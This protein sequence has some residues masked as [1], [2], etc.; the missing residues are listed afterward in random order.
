M[1]AYQGDKHVAVVSFKTIFLTCVK[2]SR[3]T[4]LKKTQNKIPFFLDYTDPP[5][6][7]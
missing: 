6:H 1:N 3:K 5:I 4:N 7:E 2:K